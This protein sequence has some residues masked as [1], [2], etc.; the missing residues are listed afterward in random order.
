MQTTTSFPWSEIAS[1]VASIVS[2]ILGGFAIWLS[3]VFYRFSNESSSKTKESA[4][5]IAASVDRLESLFDK[6]YADTFSM[7]KETVSDMRKHIWRNDGSQLEAQANEDAEQRADAKLQKLQEDF[8]HE[9][10]RLLNRQTS[11]DQTV[12]QIKDELKTLVGR[13]ITQ[14]RKAD[15]EAREETLRAHI[16]RL[17]KASP[18]RSMTFGHIKNV[19]GEKYAEETIVD[20]I[21][22][23]GGESV[24]TWEGAPSRLGY[25]DRISFVAKQNS[26]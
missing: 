5:R 11:T 23:M 7:M 12:A 24:L 1:I 25:A 2:L 18:R 16:L 10:T 17:I 6:L 20:E 26:T 8:G 21:F 22:K 15:A 9:V 19:L 14:S 4:D 13:A 3:I